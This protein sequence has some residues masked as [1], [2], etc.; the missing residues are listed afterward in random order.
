[1]EDVVDDE[2]HFDGDPVTDSTRRRLERIIKD[3]PRA[4]WPWLAA[5]A[6]GGTAFAFWQIRRRR[7]NQNGSE[8]N[9]EPDPAATNTKVHSG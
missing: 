1:V 8:N 6:A 3:Q 9:R 4:R 2:L 5:L 7:R